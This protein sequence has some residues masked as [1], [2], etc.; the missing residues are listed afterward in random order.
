M[1]T[2]TSVDMRLL[3]FFFDSQQYLYFLPL[4]QGHV[5]FRPVLTV[6]M[7]KGYSGPRLIACRG[8]PVRG[9]SRRSRFRI[10]AWR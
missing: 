3:P 2:S 6:A 5:V 1:T 7:P 8:G 4:P 10:R 9:A